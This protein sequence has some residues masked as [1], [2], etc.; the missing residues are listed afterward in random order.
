MPDGFAENDLEQAFTEA[1]P[2]VHLE[3]SPTRLPLDEAQSEGF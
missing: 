2:P 3:A 1:V